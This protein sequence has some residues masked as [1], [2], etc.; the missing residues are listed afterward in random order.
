MGLSVLAAAAALVCW[1]P[2]N[3]SAP[4]PRA[5]AESASAPA[6][7]PTSMPL[8]VAVVSVPA[9]QAS[10]PAPTYAGLDPAKWIELGFG[11][12]G[13]LVAAFAGAAA[14]FGLN[15]WH[16]SR[17]RDEAEVEAINRALLV[18]S[19]QLNYLLLYEQKELGPARADPGRH[20]HLSAQQPLNFDRWIVCAEELS[21]LYGSGGAELP[22][23]F[24]LE[25]ERFHAAIDAINGRS[26]LHLAEIQPRLEA[27]GL[28]RAAPMR[29]PEVEARIGERLTASIVRATN[30][31]FDL[32]PSAVASHDQLLRRAG[33]LFKKL[34][35]GHRFSWV[36]VPETHY[37][38]S[39]S[40]APEQANTAGS[41]S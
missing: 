9:A 2:S 41:S 5:N 27:I 21:F 17:K 39:Q 28:T 3:G 12:F 38:R 6:S 8:R 20:F 15:A 19:R 13:N 25:D 11:A 22:F 14:A 24:A 36:Q 31:V 33:P 29:G 16:E 30:T 26:Q 7:A 32:V 10:A 23:E 35:P 1:M 34:Y 37:S 4:A 18:L 40:K